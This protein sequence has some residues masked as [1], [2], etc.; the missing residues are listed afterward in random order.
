MMIFVEFAAS[1]FVKTC[2]AYL[3]PFLVG[4]CALPDDEV[5]AVVVNPEAHQRV[6]ARSQYP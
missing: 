6:H 5:C 4:R 1:L 3:N 2:S